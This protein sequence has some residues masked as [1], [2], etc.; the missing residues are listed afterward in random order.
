[1]KLLYKFKTAKKTPT[2][3]KKRKKMKYKK[4]HKMVIFSSRGIKWTRVRRT[5]FF[6]FFVRFLFPFF[7]SVVSPSFICRFIFT[8]NHVGFIYRI[9]TDFLIAVAVNCGICIH[10]FRVLKIMGYVLSAWAQ[11]LINYNSMKSR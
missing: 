2:K 8:I 9:H 3:T 1:M 4:K 7:C 5:F 10:F 11:K 6:S